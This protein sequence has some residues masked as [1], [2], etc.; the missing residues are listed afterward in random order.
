MAG[1]LAP[2]VI[3][4]LAK[5]PAHR[6]PEAAALRGSLITSGS[7]VGGATGRRATVG[8]ARSRSAAVRAATLAGYGARPCLRGLWLARCDTLTHLAE[9]VGLCRHGVAV[10]RR[11][12]QDRG[13]DV[14]LVAAT[15]RDLEE[16]MRLGNFREDLYYRLNVVNIQIPPL[17]DRREDIALLAE[18]FLQRYR[19]KNR[20]EI[21]G[22]SSEA[23]HALH[24]Y[25][26]PGN[27]REL[28]NVVER[29]VVLDRDGIIDADDIPD[30]IVETPR[31]VR[32]LTI[33]LGTSLDEIE[34]RVIQETLRM[35]GGDKKLA[36]SL[37]GIATRTIYRKI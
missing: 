19:E 36:A 14:R 32:Q 15:N 24:A 35:T 8:S 33:P 26:W 3:R 29:A 25:S 5:D 17:R 21:L 10:L 2:L 7:A 13:V 22:F 23:L 28:E 12:D 18:H 34:R 1:P 30:H 11:Q 9:L 4:C 31:E 20:R 16:E 37:L 6:Y 27:V